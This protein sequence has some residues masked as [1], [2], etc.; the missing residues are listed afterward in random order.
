M[1]M[2][3]NV[4]DEAK[5]LVKITKEAMYEG[6]KAIKPWKSHI[7]DIGKAIQSMHI[8]MAIASLKNSVVMVLE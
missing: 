3:G 5:K 1:F 7:G 4:S 2:M 6:M 8:L